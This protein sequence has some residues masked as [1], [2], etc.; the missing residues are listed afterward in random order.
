MPYATP[1]PEDEFEMLPDDAFADYR[2][3]PVEY[4]KA[5]DWGWLDGRLVAV[6]YSAASEF[7]GF[8]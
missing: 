1:I 7:Y 8:K 6:D 2:D 3:V 5:E 4:D